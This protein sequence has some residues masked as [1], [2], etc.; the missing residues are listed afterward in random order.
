MG[1]LDRFR[2]KEPKRTAPYGVMNTE[3]PC[4]GVTLDDMSHFDLKTIEKTVEKNVKKHIKT[5]DSLSDVD[6]KDT[7]KKVKRELTP[8]TQVAP[9]YKT[10]WAVENQKAEK[11]LKKKKT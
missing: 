11:R 6:L 7:R 1:I 9:Q 8:K 10:L 2:K 4:T 3:I 5:L